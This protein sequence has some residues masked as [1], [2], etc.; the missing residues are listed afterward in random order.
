MIR[1]PSRQATVINVFGGPRA[2]YAADNA[3]WADEK[4]NL[5]KAALD[6]LDEMAP[7]FSGQVIDIRDARRAGP[8]GH[9]RLAQGISST[10][11][12]RPISCSGSVLHPIGRTIALR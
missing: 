9:R 5:T 12:S 10:A 8:R 3:T 1:W 6:V 7:G 4:R 2:L 11:N